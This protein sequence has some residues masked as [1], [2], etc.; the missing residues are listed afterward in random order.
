[1]SLV[2][3]ALFI[4]TGIAADDVL[5]F[6]DQLLSGALATSIGIFGPVFQVGFET[7]PTCLDPWSALQLRLS[8]ALAHPRPAPRSSPA[9]CTSRPRQWRHHDR[10]PCPPG[11]L[12]RV[13]P[14]GHPDR[15]RAMALHGG[16][17]AHSAA[18]RGI[19]SSAA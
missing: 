4:V 9:S 14:R 11:G 1:M 6:M 2:N 13:P 15:Q 17:R 5:V 12:L 8:G 10:R 7:H 3:F 19:P 16:E 18:A